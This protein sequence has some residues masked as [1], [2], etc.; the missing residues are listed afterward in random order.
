MWDFLKNLKNFL[1]LDNRSL[2]IVLSI[3][4]VIYFLPSHIWEEINLLNFWMALR[5]YIFVVGIVSTIWFLSGSIFDMT[6]TLSSKITTN[7][8]EEKT[9]LATSRVEREYL[10]RYL[11]SDTTTLAFDYRDGIVNGLIGKRIL[12]RASEASNP[13]SFNFDYNIQ[14]WAWD[15]L[16]KHPELLKDIKPAEYK[17]HQFRTR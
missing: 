2:F 5:P 13:M 3:S 14:P 6:Q 9:I 16:K 10:A 11:H 1:S 8:N 12:Y 17:R 7:R 4:W 15:Y